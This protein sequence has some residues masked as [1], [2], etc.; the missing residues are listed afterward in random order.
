MPAIG[1]RARM[2]RA[3]GR[4][5]CPR[6]GRPTRPG[7]SSPCRSTPKIRYARTLA[8]PLG[9]PPGGDVDRHLEDAGHRHLLPDALPIASNTGTITSLRR[10]RTLWSN[11]R[12]AGRRRRGAD[13]QVQGLGHIRSIYEGLPPFPS[14]GR[15]HRG[16]PRWVRFALS[17]ARRGGAVPAERDRMS[18]GFVLQNGHQQDPPRSRFVGSFTSRV[19][20]RRCG[21]GDESYERV[22]SPTCSAFR[23]G[24]HLDAARKRA[25]S[26]KA[27]SGRRHTPDSF[28]SPSVKPGSLGSFRGEDPVA[29]CKHRGDPSLSWDDTAGCA[30]FSRERRSDE[31]TQGE[32]ASGLSPSVA[33]CLR[34]FVASDENVKF[35]E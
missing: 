7:P 24:T 8:R 28:S 25:G 9:E 13:G 11:P 22:P 34:R 23:F 2:A 35:Q 30:F 20:M 31:A 16:A 29:P 15:R 3:G 33:A 1:T 10:E 19:S 14:G 27:G 12:I 4:R 21:R 26:L 32:R 6:R 17:P 18:R 5:R